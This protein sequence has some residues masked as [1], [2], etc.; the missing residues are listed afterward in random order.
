MRIHEYQA[1]KF[2]ADYG[3]SVPRG[4]MAKTAA[5]AAGIAK[6]LGGRVVIKAQIHAGARGKAGGIKTVDSPDEAERETS[7][8]LGSRLK[9]HQT[10]EEGLIVNSVLVEEALNSIKELYLGIAIDSATGAP[11]LMASEA[12]GMEIEQI[13]EKTPEKIVKCHVDPGTLQLRGFQAREIGF[14]LKLG[15]KERAAV[16]DIVPRL[17]SLFVEKDC[18]LAEI[19]PLSVTADGRV[20]AVDA[21]LNFDDSAL[22]RHADIKELYDPHQENEL[23]MMAK[24]KGIASYV[25]LEGDIGSMVNGAGLAMAVMDAIKH[26]G[27][28]PANF[29]DLG[30]VNNPERVL[31]AFKIIASDPGVKCILVNIFGGMA[32]VDVITRGL[33]EAYSQIDIK[34][35]V[36]AR[37]KGTNAAEGERIL[38]ESGINLI[39]AD[40]FHEAI[41]K[42]VTAASGNVLG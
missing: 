13:A 32:R 11:L 41:E 8:L 39:K 10:G 5:E 14:G 36:V 28:K 6:E 12:G 42:A 18:S 30:T 4:A 25:K 19:N 31:N 23:E 9:T 17:C 26:I 38:S 1:K 2:L 15:D 35:P 22:Y 37:L 16:I 40:A 21:K 7:S 34:V 3:V 24:K 27:G 33:V 20:L 29:L